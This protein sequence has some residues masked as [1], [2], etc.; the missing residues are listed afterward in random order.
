MESNFRILSNQAYDDL[1]HLANSSQTQDPALSTL[2]NVHEYADIL[3]Q[4]LFDG[5]SVVRARSLLRACATWGHINAAS[6]QNAIDEFLRLLS[7][8]ISLTG[9]AM[10]SLA[11]SAWMTTICGLAKSTFL[12]A[13]IRRMQTKNSKDLPAKSDGDDEMN[14]FKEV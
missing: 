8:H 4:A 13:E 7:Q 1:I 6:D 2:V 3:T 5:S 10:E 14:A 12:L 9:H 11:T